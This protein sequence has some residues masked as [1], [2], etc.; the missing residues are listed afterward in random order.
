MRERRKTEESQ[1]GSGATL[2]GKRPFYDVMNFF[3]LLFAA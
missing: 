2:K 1:S 3:G